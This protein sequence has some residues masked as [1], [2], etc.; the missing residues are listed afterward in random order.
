MERRHP[1][2][3]AEREGAALDELGVGRIEIDEE[4]CVRWMNQEAERLTGWPFGM[5]VGV[6]VDR[7]LTTDAQDAPS[8]LDATSV[9]RLERRGGGETTTLLRSVRRRHG[10]VLLLRSV[11]EPETEPAPR[12]DRVTGL[13][14]RDA[15]LEATEAVALGSFLAIVDVQVFDLVVAACGYE[16]AD[17]LLQWVAAR[18]REAIDDAELL[19]HLTTSSFGLLLRRD[20]AG[21]AERALR[22]V[23]R[24]LASFRFNWGACSFR[25]ETSIGAVERGDETAGETLEQALRAC[26]AARERGDPRLV[27]MPRRE[28]DDGARRREALGWVANLE[29]NLESGRATLHAQAV[30][31]LRGERGA[32]YEV[33]LRVVDESGAARGPGSIIEVAERHGRV[34]TL[35]RWVIDR[36]LQALGEVGPRELR[37]IDTFAINL[38]GASVTSDTLFDYIVDAFGR[39]AVPPH[40]ICFEIT[41]TAAISDLETARYLVSQL[42]A[43]GARVALDDFGAG[44][45]SF[46]Y[47]R[48]LDVDTVKIDGSIVRRC[49]QDAVDRCI[50]EAVVRIAAQLGAKTV[51]EWVEDE[52]TEALLRDLGVDRV[53]GFLR[54]RPRA[55]A[56]VLAEL[57]GPKGGAESA[58]ASE[59]G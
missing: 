28:E 5:A 14:G 18:L 39:Y 6:S 30:H 40:L 38:S 52:E 32:Y 10:A 17:L 8:T 16:A 20:G 41:E 48:Q 21:A 47:L 3:V 57:A 51:A 29:P 4:G 9:V 58:A 7:L 13:L 26:R 54:G 34:E 49:A 1:R 31:S 36:T 42:K 35:D 23:Q 43:L 56:G 53:Q 50:V 27:L 19:T 24:D 37:A 25:V 2:E 46:S 12:R 33:L 59:P 22:R 45:A 44:V 11:E 55:L 15:L